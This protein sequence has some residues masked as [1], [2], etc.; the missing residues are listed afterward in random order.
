MTPPRYGLGKAIAQS[1]WRLERGLGQQLRWVVLAPDLTLRAMDGDPPAGEM[2]AVHR[3]SATA[4]YAH[5]FSTPFPLDESHAT[6][7]GHHGQVWLA[8]RGAALI[9]SSTATSSAVDGLYVLPTE[10]G[11]GVASALLSAL[12]GVSRLWVL[13]GNHDGRRWYERR[14]WCAN[15]QRQLSYGVWELRYV[16]KP[17]RNVLQHLPAFDQAPGSFTSR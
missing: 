17:C 4:A 1:S 6:W 15:G 14:G 3:A 16:Q 5:I 10:T 13:E 9:G 8:R 7:A 12:V 11:R 2:A